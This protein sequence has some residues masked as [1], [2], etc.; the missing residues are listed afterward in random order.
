MKNAHKLESPHGDAITY[1][2]YF[3]A[4]C[5]ALAGFASLLALSV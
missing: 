4:L 2:L 5:A 1:L 3:G